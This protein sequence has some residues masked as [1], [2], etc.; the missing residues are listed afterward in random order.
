MRTVT[1]YTSTGPRWGNSSYNSSTAE[2]KVGKSGTSTYYGR[3]GFE[4]LPSTWYIKSIKLRLRR[5]DDYSTKS[6][7][8]GS[9][10]SGDWDDKYNTDFVKSI[11]VSSGQNTK[12]WDLTAYKSIMQG[13]TGTWYLHIR[14]GSGDNSYCEFSGG[15]SGSAPRL[16]IEYEEATT[17]IPTE[18]FTVGAGTD[19]TVGAEGTGLTHTLNY[20]IGEYS[21]TVC[22]GVSGGYVEAGWTPPLNLAKAILDAARGEITMELI[23]YLGEEES[24]RINFTY[25][26]DVPESMVPAISGVT[27]EVVNPENDD[28]GVYVQTRSR[29]KCTIMADSVYDAEIAKYS[30]TIAGKTYTSES[31]EIITD[32]LDASGELTG[33][34]KVVD[35]RGREAEL[36]PTA[37]IMVYS[38]TPPVITAFNVE[39]ADHEGRSVNSG[40][41]LKYSLSCSFSPIG[42][43]NTR[44]GSICFRPVNGDFCDPIILNG[45]MEQLGQVYSFTLEG[46]LG[47]TEN[48]EEGSIG[49]DGYVVSAT[50]IDGFGNSVGGEAELSSQKI[51]YDLHGS[52]EG[53]A[54]GGEAVDEGVL[55]V[56]LP[57]R[58]REAPTYD[59]PAAAREA[60]GATLANL[61]PNLT[62]Y[63]M[64]FNAGSNGDVKLW[65]NGGSVNINT[66]VLFNT[67]GSFRFTGGY[68]YFGEHLRAIDTTVRLG[69]PDNRFNR[70]YVTLSESV[71]SDGRLKTDIEDLSEDLIYRLRPRKYRMKSDPGK[72]RFGLIAQETK[73]ALDE[74]GIEDADLYGDENPESLSLVYGELIAPLIAAAQA[75][76]NRI[77][78]LEARIA[79]LEAN[80]G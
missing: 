21:G 9:A 53:M 61:L 22:A 68:S 8:V 60:L 14:H 66:N 24:S 12:E 32:I 79:E 65:G 59:E 50:L 71:S 4:A 18:G 49:S 36:P 38:Y 40:T 10:K 72:L 80:I 23:S 17:S 26:L 76:K 13:Y 73:A 1:R 19:I 64:T 5:T 58:F 35:T 20:S 15:T 41:F 55:D 42:A 3:F 30:L 25:P 29:T 43:L 51:W 39:R 34:V 27:Y 77:D 54:I 63:G 52:G 48:P 78:N 45:D 57:T 28:I 47:Q 6:L 11:S 46:L 67:T 56:Y 44:E 75:Q 33:T 2:L 16:V 69:G 7:K 37:A 70:V 31:N 62:A 74:L